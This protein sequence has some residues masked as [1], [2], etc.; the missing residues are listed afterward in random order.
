MHPPAQELPNPAPVTSSLGEALQTSLLRWIRPGSSL[1]RCNG[2]RRPDADRGT[3]SI[4]LTRHHGGL[5]SVPTR[6]GM[7]HARPCLPTVERQAGLR[8]VPG[9]EGTYPG[10]LTEQ[11]VGVQQ[12]QRVLP[13]PRLFHSPALAPAGV[14]PSSGTWRKKGS[15][16]N[17]LPPAGEGRGPAARAEPHGAGRWWLG[18]E[19]ECR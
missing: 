4:S 13:K 16:R 14:V 8:A 9:D 17:Q 2:Q 7:R 11:S 5:G 1:P 18:G 15:Q 6:D 19:G 12:W 10:A 3:D